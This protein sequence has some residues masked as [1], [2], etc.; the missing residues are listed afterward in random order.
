MKIPFKQN[1][2]FTILELVIALTII[3]VLLPATFA[4]FMAN[5]RAQTK[6]LVLQDVKKNGDAALDIM[7]S[8]IKVYGRELEQSD[9]TPVC[10]TSSSSYSGDIYFVDQTGARFMFHEDTGRIASESAT[11][12]YLTSD[13]VIVSDFNLSCSRES[14]FTSP[15]VSVSFTIDQARLTTRAEESASLDYQT[16][17][18]L[19]NL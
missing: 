18:R 15:L 10:S 2:G 13:S 7:E 8:L 17:I 14:L 6:V 3:G 19:R 1:A 16:K 5:L 12:A 11:T 9:G 4:I